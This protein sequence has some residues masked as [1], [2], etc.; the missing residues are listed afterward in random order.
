MEF[1]TGH[2]PDVE[3]TAQFIRSEMAEALRKAPYQVN[4]LIGGYDKIDNQAKLF[5][6]I[7][8]FAVD[9][10]RNCEWRNICAALWFCSSNVL[11]VFWILRVS[12]KLSCLLE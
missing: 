5:G 7:R 6:I 12:A 3:S 1:R 11:H 4:C 9:L 2:E 8:Q 10:L